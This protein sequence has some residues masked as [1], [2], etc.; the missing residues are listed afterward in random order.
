MSERI[1][2]ETPATTGNL[3]RRS[4]G[5]VAK[6]RVGVSSRMSRGDRSD[7]MSTTKPRN[8]RHFGTVEGGR[9]YQALHVDSKVF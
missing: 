1:L 6:F 5:L 2:A 3:F 4:A 7:A 9:V 8:P